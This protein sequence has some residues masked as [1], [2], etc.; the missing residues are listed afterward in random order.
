MKFVKLTLLSIIVIYSFSS[1]KKS[2][3]TIN[4]ASA[5]VI[6]AGTSLNSNG[7]NVAT[8]WVNGVAAT[9]TDSATPSSA[10][11]ITVSGNDIYIAGIA[12]IAGKV[13]AVYWKNG[14]MV[15]LTNGNS[16]SAAANGIAVSGNNVYV[17]GNAVNGND[18]IAVGFNGP[19]ATYWNNNEA[20]KLPDSAATGGGSSSA[21]AIAVDGGNVYISGNISGRITSGPAFWKNGILTSLSNG[22]YNEKATC[23]AVANSDVYVGGSTD[24]NTMVYWKNGLVTVVEKSS[25]VGSA[26]SI[27]AIN[28]DVYVTGSSQDN[29]GL[30]VATFWKNSVPVQFEDQV[31]SGIVAGYVSSASGIA[32][33]GNDTYVCGNVGTYA[34]YW[35]NGKMNL[36]SKNSTANAIALR[37]K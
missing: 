9:L 8:Y 33:Q 24:Q 36:L 34:V 30:Y 20:V 2:A 32:V 23:I 14:T 27:L 35:L 18:I 12:T 25:Q 16:G 37:P 11:A 13:T 7:F 6:V 21:N 22:T 10:N 4:C 5:D 19:G 17:A 26:T 15:K 3:N 29:K 1:C 28:N 31:V